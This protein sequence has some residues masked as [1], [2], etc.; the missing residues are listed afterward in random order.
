MFF[1]KF[2]QALHRTCDGFH[3]STIRQTKVTFT[4]FSK[5]NP[6]DNSNSVSTSKILT[7]CRRLFLITLWTLSKKEECPICLDNLKAKCRDIVYSEITTLHVL[8]FHW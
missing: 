2:F 6:W 7:K 5:S 8:S 4:V 1:H 3:A